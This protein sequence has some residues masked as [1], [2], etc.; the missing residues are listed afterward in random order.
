VPAVV[1]YRE[2]I[3]EY[4]LHS[5]SK[6]ENGD[7]FDRG[8][9]RRRHVRA[10]AVEYIGKEANRWEEQ[11]FLGETPEAQI[12]YGS[13]PAATRAILKVIRRAARK[14]GM[15]KLADAAQLSRQQL[16]TLI[17]KKGN[18]HPATV[19]RLMRAVAELERQ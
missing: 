11:F 8:I 2:A 14:F 10:V 15:T 16:T 12:E 6:F 19:V 17:G 5:E 4:H 13:S 9:T 7:L 18:P 3:A 1:A